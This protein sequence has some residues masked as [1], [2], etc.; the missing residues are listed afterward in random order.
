VY[1]VLLL[2]I[3]SNLTIT[4]L[5]SLGRPPMLWGLLCACWWIWTRL[6]GTAT[7]TRRR[8]PVR[9]ALFA[10]ASVVVVSYGLGQL[11]GIPAPE[12]SPATT[13]LLRLVSWA[14]VVLTAN[15]GIATRERLLT[16]L[17]RVA[18]AGGVFALFGLLQFATGRS[19]L[20]TASIPGIS[21]DAA[22][23]ALQSR[24]GFTRASGTAIHP[25][26]YAAVLASTLPLAI[27]LAL[28]EHR[29][30]VLAR[31]WA[32]ADLVLAAVLAVSRSAVIGVIAG[33]AVLAWTWSPKVRRAAAV[34][35]V[36]VMAFV[37]VA[38]PGMVGTIRG[39]FLGAGT[40]SSTVS[41]TSSYSTAFDIASRHPFLG[42]GF[43]TFLPEYRIL[44]N[45]LL[46]FVIELGLVGLL[47]FIALAASAVTCTATARRT[48]LLRLDSQLAHALVA[49]IV[50]TGVLFA[51]FDA[52]TFPMAGGMF[53]LVVGLAG[54]SR[55]VFGRDHWRGS[56]SG[57]PDR[58][59][60]LGA[61]ESV[62]DAGPG[63]GA[64]RRRAS[65]CDGRST[66]R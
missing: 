35:A 15:D 42:R 43:G 65:R 63:P 54:A 51:F 36:V 48:A 45:Q 4:A 66:N 30:G 59:D 22:A 47:S 11:R 21:I 12:V 52:L 60:V 2:A 40:D 44:D 26:E 13:G 33:L 58:T 41:R 29:R 6:Q 32:P 16:L 5:G 56:A 46:D 8:Q 23:S 38:V 39:L 31:W 1:V 55:N 57:G 27:T 10:F 17:R 62:V 3:P 24:G 50:A 49:S 14:G 20:L 53:F 37:Y 28:E 34:A 64:P 19:L 7:H 61:D 18:V 9:I 25:L